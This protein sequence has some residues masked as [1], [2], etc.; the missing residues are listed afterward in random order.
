MKHTLVAAMVAAGIMMTAGAQAAPAKGGADARFEA[1]Y[2]AEWKWRVGERL[3]TD[4][5][6]RGNVRAELPRVDA[7][8]QEARLRHWQGVLRQLD[9]LSA[10]GL[11]PAARINYQ[12]YRAQIAAFV[13]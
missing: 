3:A 6:A 7:K 13:E 4:E 2:K 12:V 11:S 9:A 5:D 10:A 1:I 8:T